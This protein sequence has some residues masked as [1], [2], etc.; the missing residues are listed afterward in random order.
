MVTI[1]AWFIL[2]ARCID[3]LYQLD[4]LKCNKAYQEMKNV[5][6]NFTLF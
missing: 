6:K 1:Y 2:V 3:I 5:N 4:E